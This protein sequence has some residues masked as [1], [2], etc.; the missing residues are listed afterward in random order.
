MPKKNYGEPIPCLL[1]LSPNAKQSKCRPGEC[2]TCGWNNAVDMQRKM[3]IRQHG[4]TKDENG[5]RR[6]VVRKEKSCE[7]KA[8]DSSG[9]ILL[10]G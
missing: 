3:Q 10:C 8:E 6:L 4:M 5:K 7:R 2:R 9:S 1:E